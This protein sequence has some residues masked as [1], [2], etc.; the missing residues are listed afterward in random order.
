MIDV[1]KNV[2]L[3]KSEK[4]NE[5]SR[6]I[7]NPAFRVSVGLSGCMF[8]DDYFRWR[9]DGQVVGSGASGDAGVRVREDGQVPAAAGACR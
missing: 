2:V 6:G 4:S 8:V 3:D 7:K 5:R 9:Q 1:A